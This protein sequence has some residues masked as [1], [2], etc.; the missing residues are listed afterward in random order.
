MHLAFHR[1]AATRPDLCPCD[2]CV[3]AANLKLKFVAHIGEVATQTIRDGGSSLESTS[4]SSTD[5]E[6]PVEDPEYVLFSEE[7]YRTG[8]TTLDA[9]REVSQDLE[10]IGLVRTYVAGIEGVAGSLPPLPEPGPLERVGR[11]LGVAGRGLPYM[12]GLR[13]TRRATASA[14]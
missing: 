14:R 8:E 3:Q 7:L 4:S 1:S 5:A 12:L 2:D 13:R 9:V 10:G 6:E 11:T